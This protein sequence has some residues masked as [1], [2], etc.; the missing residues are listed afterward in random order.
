MSLPS[1]KLLRRIF[2]GSAAIAGKN[3]YTSMPEVMEPTE[4]LINSSKALLSATVGTSFAGLA[5]FTAVA[6]GGYCL[7]N[8]T[9][10]I[11]YGLKASFAASIISIHVMGGMFGEYFSK[12]DLEPALPVPHTGTLTA[13]EIDRQLIP[14]FEP[15]P[16]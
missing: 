14:Q 7:L 13:P 8:N 3:I 6:V 1:V 11:E 5:V 2:F 16:Q 4:K 9:K 10:S 15:L 12:S